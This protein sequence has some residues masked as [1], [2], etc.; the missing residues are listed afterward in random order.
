MKRPVEKALALAVGV[1]V[2]LVA[3]CGPQEPPSVK[4]SRAI[5]AENMQL[6]EQLEQRSKEIEGLKELHGKEMKEQQEALA[7]CLEEKE[8]WKAK[9]QQNIREQ[10][11]GVL[12]AVME[13]N[14]KLREENEKLKAQIEGPK[15]EQ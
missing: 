8:S 2:I 10:V 15:A 5:A 14:S 1:I 12:D 6:R 3:G 13:E 4:K 9:S 11:K 7:K